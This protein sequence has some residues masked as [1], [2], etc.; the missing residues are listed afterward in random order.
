MYAATT[1]RSPA[2]LNTITW[3]RHSRRI[4]PM[5]RS[6][7]A[8]GVVTAAACIWRRST[9][10][11]RFPT[12]GALRESEVRPTMGSSRTSLESR[13]GHRLARPAALCDAGSSMSKTGESRADARRARSL[14][15]RHGAPRASHAIAGT[16]TPTASDLPKLNEDA[17]GATIH[18]GELVS[19]R[20]DLQV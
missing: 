4:E 14:A 17:D 6:T 11:L 18:H 16:A 13:C 12:S 15:V 7:F 10:S 1:L 3:S 19:Q 8:T 20:D 5:M 2:A 9:D